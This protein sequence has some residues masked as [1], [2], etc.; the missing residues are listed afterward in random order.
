[1]NMITWYRQHIQSI[2]WMKQCFCLPGVWGCSPL[3][4]RSFS[5]WTTWAK[6]QAAVSFAWLHYSDQAVVE[7]FQVLS[8]FPALALHSYLW[9]SCRKGRGR[10]L[11]GRVESTSLNLKVQHC[12]FAKLP[13]GVT[14][15]RN[16]CQK[17]SSNERNEWMKA[18]SKKWLLY[19]LHHLRSDDRYGIWPY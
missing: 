12:G 3:A 19:R 17:A 2:P 18:S 6:K 9:M 13:C 8:F 1:M 5:I 7:W 4:A 15:T 11:T 14:G 16:A 10:L